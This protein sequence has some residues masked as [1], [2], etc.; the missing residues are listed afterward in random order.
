[1][2]VS[3]NMFISGRYY[4]IYNHAS[5]NN[6]LFRDEADY[7]ECIRLMDKYIVKD[8]ISSVAICLMPNHYHFL[9]RQ[10]SELP[11]YIL[12]NKLWWAYSRYYNQ[13]YMGKGSIFASKMQHIVVDKENYLCQLVGYIHLNPV[14]AGL[15]LSPENWRWSNYSEFIG[16]RK[17]ICTDTELLQ[18]MIP[19]L[20]NYAEI[21]DNLLEDTELSRYMFD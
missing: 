18:N 4:H 9:F 13:K 5:Q 7:H 6:L 16:K 21:I 10:N 15:A 1:M 19:F 12:L 8:Y 3:S 17:L 14:K 2:R 11:I 20:S